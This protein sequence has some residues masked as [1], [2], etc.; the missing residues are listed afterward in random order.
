MNAK[1][2]YKWNEL[3]MGTCYY[4]EHWDKKLWADDLDRMKKAGI[5]VI[6]IAEFAWSKVEPEEG[7]F[8]YDFFDEFLDLCS[9]KQMKVIFG[10]PTATPPAWLT[11]KYPEV[12]NARKDGVLLRHGGRRHYNY[13]SPVYQRLCARVVEREAAHYAK[14]PAIVGWQIDNEINC[15]ENEFYSEADSV[16]FREFLRK[17]YGTLE[18]LNE[19]WGT[20]FWNQTYT[21]WDQIYVLRP[22]LSQGINPHQHLDYIRFISESARHFCKMQA[23]IIKKYVKPGDYITT[24]GKFWNLDNH[25]MEKESLDVYCYDSYP[26]FAFGLDRDPLHSD[27]LND[28]KWS[29]NLA[30]VRSICPH[31]GIMEQQ[32][33]GNGWTT[34]MEAP[35]PRPGQLTV[36]AM[37]SVAHGADYISFF[38]WRTCTFGTEIY[39]H[40][41]LDYDNRENRKYR[42][43]QDFYKKLK[44]IDGVCNS[45]YKAAFA[46]VKD[47]DNEWDTSVDTWHNRVAGA[48]EQGIFKAAQLTHTPY[49]IVYLQED[50]ELTDLTKYPVLFYAHP[51]LISEERVK[52]LK[53]YVEQGGTLVIGCRSGYKDMNGKCVMLPQPGLLAEL[54]GTDVRDFTFTSPAEDEV[55]AEFGDK[56]IPMPVFNDI[57]T[58]LEGTKTLAVYGNS[59]Y[60]GNPALT[61]H[62]VGKGQVLHLGATFNKE[63]TEA[64]FDYLKIKE[65]FRE[66]IEAPETAEVIM[67]EKDGEK[68][69]FVLNYQAEKIEYTLQKPMIALYDK[70]EATGRCSLPA[71]GTAVYKVI[72]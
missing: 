31:F 42:E 55:F 32:S 70:T 3:T 5:S 36:W 41:I 29:H 2:N 48:S 14:H 45:E 68:Y 49:D 22:V 25:K 66:Y 4:P 60:E 21:E 43:V 1:Q 27:D 9:E 57:I 11:E 61:C 72:E 23:E 6:R 52:L 37:Q 10:T 17:Q 39:W 71:F 7:V 51:V 33:G 13:N 65:P 50:S 63:N 15:E 44:A 59:Y 34:R 26:D 18:K 12:L 64:L 56:K 54:T 62:A 67:R 58:P 46:I 53:E 20:T 35:S 40:G 8:T 24:N 47:Y 69:I 19:A 30:E 38:R 28:R 16:A